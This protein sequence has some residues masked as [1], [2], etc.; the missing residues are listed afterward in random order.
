MNP[1]NTSRYYRRNSHSNRA[2][3]II[4]HHKKANNIHNNA[5]RLT[6]LS[7]LRCV[8]HNIN[9]INKP[10]KRDEIIHKYIIERI[11]IICLIHTRLCQSKQKQIE[12]RYRRKYDIILNANPKRGILV[13][14]KNDRDI[15]WKLLHKK[16][17]GNLITLEIKYDNQNFIMHFAYAPSTDDISR[18]DFFKHLEHKMDETNIKQTIITGDLN[19]IL[20]DNNKI[21]YISTPHIPYYSM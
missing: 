21:N 15:H 4:Q 9:G 16:D 13:M 17:D 1:Y 10:Q 11:D 20:N 6:N 14:I 5:K 2:N 7:G 19:V 3:S 8:S 12:N 18:I